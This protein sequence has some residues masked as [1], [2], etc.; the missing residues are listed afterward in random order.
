RADEVRAMAM[1]GRIEDGALF[2]D[3][4]AAAEQVAPQLAELRPEIARAAG[5]PAHVTGSGSSM[6]VLASGAADA[7]RLAEDI[8]RATGCVSR[9]VRIG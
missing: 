8:E 9:P 4:A 7:Q 2:N 5:R 1:E 3:L 6:F